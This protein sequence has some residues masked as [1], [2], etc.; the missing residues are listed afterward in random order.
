[1]AKRAGEQRTKKR[2][3]GEKD[4]RS[5]PLALS[6]EGAFLGMLEP[7]YENCHMVSMLPMSPFMRQFPTL[8]ILLR[9]I[10]RK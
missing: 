7:V 8:Y 10:G 4:T 3:N 1:M 2:N 5:I 9:S 6:G